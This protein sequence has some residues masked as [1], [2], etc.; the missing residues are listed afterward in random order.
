MRMLVNTPTVTQHIASAG[1]RYCTFKND[2]ADAARDFTKG[3]LA[4]RSTA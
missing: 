4:R 3:V 1:V 2:G